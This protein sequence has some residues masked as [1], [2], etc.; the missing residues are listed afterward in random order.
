MGKKKKRYYYVLQIC[1]GL[2]ARSTTRIMKGGQTVSVGHQRVNTKEM[3]VDLINIFHVTS[4][5]S[6][7][8]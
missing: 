6:V 4:F 5:G 8:K 2:G 1:N 3:P 7:V